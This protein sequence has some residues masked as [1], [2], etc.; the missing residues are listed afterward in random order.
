MDPQKV[1]VVLNWEGPTI[2]TEVKSFVG[3]AGY[4]QHFVE[5]FLEDSWTITPSNKKGSQVHLGR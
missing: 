4:Y 2:I 3:L 1:E 5:G